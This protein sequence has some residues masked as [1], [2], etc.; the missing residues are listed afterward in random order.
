MCVCARARVRGRG[1]AHV[2][3]RVCVRVR[4]RLCA[5]ACVCFFCKKQVGLIAISIRRILW[6]IE[7]SSC[8]R[9]LWNKG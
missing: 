4:T 1:R 9:K 3:G 2:R 8:V 5:R 6:Y 7:K